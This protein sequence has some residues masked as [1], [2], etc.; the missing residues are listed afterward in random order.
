MLPRV[1]ERAMSGGCA[2]GWRL[3]FAA[4]FAAGALVS[5]AGCGG[6]DQH[7]FDP[8]AGAD[9]SVSQQAPGDDA[10]TSTF[11]NGD[12]GGSASFGSP[13]PSTTQHNDFATPVFDSP[14]GGGGSVPTNA[15]AL[16]GPTS[17]GARSGGPCLTEPGGNAL[18]PRN[19]LRPLFRWSA[20]SGQ[21]LFELRL[22]T[23]NQTSD[24]VVYTSA[25]S[26]TM[27]KALWDALRL[28]SNDVPIAV[29][30][31]GGSLSGT[32]LTGESLGSGGTIGV[33]PAEA[34]GTIVYWTSAD[35]TTL[36]GFQVGDETVGATL[37]TSQ[38]QEVTLGTGKCMGCHT[39]APDG[40]Y[41]ILTESGDNWGDFVALVDPDA[42][43]VGSA[44]PFLGAGAKTTLAQGP[45]GMSAVT[46]A[47]WSKG[48]HVMLASDDT[49]I[50]W[51]D[52][53]AAD[54]ASARGAIPRTGAPSGTVAVAPAWS[55]DGSTVVYVASALANA[56]RPGSALGT[57]SQ[58]DPGSTADLYRFSYNNR[59]GGAVTPV[60]GA[61]DPNKQ[62]YYPTY[63]PDDTY[64]VYTECDNGLS[65]YNQSK[66]EIYVIP[67]AGGT[68]T[69]LKSNSPA[70]CSGTVSPGVTNSWAKWAPAVTKTPDGRSFYWIVFS[71]KREGTTPQLF[72]SGMQVDT[73]GAV[74]TY[75][76]LYLWNQPSTEGNH[77]PA[78]EYFNVPPPP[79]VVPK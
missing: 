55:H 12:D 51:I 18:F 42:G 54:S 59:K 73:K 69:R 46:K 79:P 23:P 72:V 19:W 16:F 26:W 13:D 14:D 45:L 34:P 76:A 50:V 40:E 48:D 62:E 31:R 77:T 11:S 74:T 67:S 49:D 63:S 70:A 17:Q 6:H 27:P 15:P 47:H 37:V 30:I 24:L 29:S 71:S 10:S 58:T 57:Y 43:A 66:A 36:K 41:S 7:A 33:A 5:L 8:A 68:P 78:W 44:P 75:G 20:P 32:Q 3:A 9:G 65:M 56:G 61:A 2:D 25:T 38:V 1:N 60:M 35:G 4:A 53:E 21:N 64:L 52:L 22:H 28:N 39:G